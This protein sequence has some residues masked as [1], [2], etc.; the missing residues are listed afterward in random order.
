MRSPSYDPTSSLRTRRPLVHWFLPLVLGAFPAGGSPRAQTPSPDTQWTVGNCN[1]DQRS[2]LADAIVMLSLLFIGSTAEPCVPLCDVTGD[3]KFNLADPISMLSYLF[4]SVPLPNTA[5]PVR[6]EQCDGIDNDCN[7]LID[8]DCPSA[9]LAAVHLA[10]DPVTR[11]V[12]GSAEETV[13]YRIYIGRQS[14]Q[15]TDVRNIGAAT[16]FRIYGLTAGVSYFFALTALDTNGNES[17]Y[18][19]EISAI[20]EVLSL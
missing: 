12:Q 7:G 14:Q 6:D 17:L 15:Y 20:P 4:S 5:T 8:D 1:L 10:W 9:G 18:S 2:D 3:D 11:D 19:N 16:D 13:R